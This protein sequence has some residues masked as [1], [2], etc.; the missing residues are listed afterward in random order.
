M[1]YITCNSVSSKIMSHGHVFGSL[2]FS[3]MPRR[4]ACS[5]WTKDI[6]IF[7]KDF[8]IIPIN[9]DMHWCLAIVCNPGKLGEK[10]KGVYSS[11]VS[12]ESLK[13]DKERSKPGKETGNVNVSGAMHVLFLD[14]MKNNRTKPVM[15]RIRNYLAEEW[16]CKYGKLSG[17]VNGKV[18]PAASPIVPEQ[19]NGCDC[20]VF[21]L[22]FMERL[23]TADFEK[24]SK[25]LRTE[26]VTEARSEFN[27]LFGRKWFTQ[28]D[29]A[30]K[31]HRIAC[32][33]RDLSTSQT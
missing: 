15:S 20:G 18:L 22:E 17:P 1:A 32:L 19:R 11:I 26:S 27:K 13:M 29:V 4:R 14:S 23:L 24:F 9:I 2:F 33:V 28:V 5:K 30:K 3:L 12:K 25:V 16:E 10:V 31:R 7:K 8:I 6:D 21:I